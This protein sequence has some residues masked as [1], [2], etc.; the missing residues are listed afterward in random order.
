MIASL[1][2]RI[3]GSTHLEAS[4]K[5]LLLSS[6]NAER[7]LI[8]L[9]VN[10]G[11]HQRR[12]LASLLFSNR[13]SAHALTYLRQSLQKLRQARPRL[14]LK[15]DAE[16][17]G[18]DPKAPVSLD[19]AALLQAQEDDP[20]SC[21][22]AIALYRGPLL[23][24]ERGETSTEWW[25]WVCDQRRIVEEKLASCYQA[26]LRAV[27]RQDGADPMGLLR[28]WMDWQP[29]LDTPHREA[30]LYLARNGRVSE[31]L[32]LYAEYAERRITTTGRKPGEDL[33]ALRDRLQAETLSPRLPAPAPP[34]LTQE[35][36]AHRRLVIMLAIAPDAEKEQ[37][38]ALSIEAHLHQYLGFAHQ[39]AA[40]YGGT[41][42]IGGD[43]IIEILFGL[44][45]PAQ[46]GVIRA[47]QAAMTLRRLLPPGHFP[48]LGIHC[49]LTLIAAGTQ[50]V[51]TL[52]AVSHAAAW[53]NHQRQGAVLTE[54][55]LQ[56]LSQDSQSLP[57][58]PLLSTK[59]F[60][61]SIALYWLPDMPLLGSSISR[62]PLVGRDT[63]YAR[64]RA[65]AAAAVSGGEGRLLWI[66]GDPGIGKS[67]LMRHVAQ[68]L[69]GQMQV[70]E[71]VCQ[72]LYQESF[73]HPVAALV[74]QLFGLDRGD[75][76][77]SR[78]Q[79]CQQLHAMGEQDPL[80]HG[81]WLRWLRLDTED[82]A[83][84]WL[85][86][87]RSVLFDSVLEILGSHLFPETR[88]ILVEDFHWADP[89]SLEL[90]GRHLRFL[91]EKPAL[92]LISSR[93]RLPL[94]EGI[95]RHEETLLL[96]P[97]DP[98]S[99][100]R[101]LHALP[102][103]HATPEE[104]TDIVTR[105]GGIPL[106]VDL[107][108]RLPRTV[109][110][111]P[112]PDRIR[113]I[114]DGQIARASSALDLLQAAAVVGEAFS[115]SF[116]HRI[117]P[118]H[119]MA[120][121]RDQAER[122]ATLGLWQPI[123]ELWTFRHELLREAVYDC[124]PQKPLQRLHRS[125]AQAL[126]EKGQGHPD[127]LAHH[128]A[129]GGD[130]IQAA[131]Y[132]IQAARMALAFEQFDQA[133]AG[134]S[135]A[136][137]WLEDDGS[138]L[139]LAKALAGQYVLLAIH[140]GYS[141]PATKAAL[142]SLETLCARQKLWGMERLAADYGRWV[143]DAGLSGAR[144]ARQQAR[145]IGERAYD[146]VPASIRD[147]IAAY[148]M[149][150]SLFWLGDL[151]EAQDH[152]RRAVNLWQESQ[153]GLVAWLTCERYREAAIAYWGVIEAIQGQPRKG[154]LRCAQA[155][156]GLDGT[157]HVHTLLFLQCVQMTMGFWSGEARTSLAIAQQVL[158]TSEKQQMLLWSIF[159]RAAAAWAQVR[160]GRIQ[161]R[162]GLARIRRCQRDIAVAW[163]FGA[164]FL[165]L[166][167]LDVAHRAGR[168]IRPFWGSAHRHMQRHAIQ[169]L[170]PD[171]Q[172][173]RN[174]IAERSGSR[175]QPFPRRRKISR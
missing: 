153:A 77:R 164:G 17:I 159:A 35:R 20:V 85:Q 36:A 9:S 105:S 167:E 151:D 46:D 120:G 127:V 53:A 163:R 156:E 63:E 26:C 74:E 12:E 166:L 69:S 22:K 160:L 49:G 24:D 135:R 43:R 134:F 113:T 148:A 18:L 11:L 93:W 29:L 131:H 82:A 55:A 140:R 92:M 72:P 51:G 108:T 165:H 86:D 30:M 141:S 133:E 97:W 125:V 27:E 158:R 121:L 144:A 62:H 98:D 110:S 56:M 145:T 15:V 117:L 96:S 37:V 34:L 38:S 31:S 107:L 91:H 81:L 64:I 154:Y 79:V 150:W 70:A 80:I 172:R 32:Q 162:R 88:A 149:G 84:G 157:P 155:A 57:G 102:D 168:N 10:P 16:R 136:V 42:R 21:R 58:S 109:S 14:A 33:R 111:C 104:E 50:P 152:L 116:L 59:V 54:P 1:Q 47:L 76:E 71:Y 138:S 87:Y 112:M 161:P 142:E 7:L 44:E 83:L 60:G 143:I 169:V 39:V 99:T 118:L 103:W 94:L 124:I 171:L 114:L 100:S 13:D 4:G 115:L 147:G 25:D 6:R 123:H 129:S 126:E 19:Y 130:L 170:M 48:R 5:P 101:F 175:R 174:G 75:P 73:L 45:S 119:S 65:A 137:R 61:E 67:H 40:R 95:A 3:L 122:L 106:F 23:A 146:G 28:E 2:I 139:S 52:S 132:Q 90:V 128:H 89:G 78:L 68:D 41:V 173:L 66:V 8:Y